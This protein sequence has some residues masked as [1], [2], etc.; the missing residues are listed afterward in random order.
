MKRLWQTLC[1]QL[2]STLR[3]RVHLALTT[4][5]LRHQLA[6][7]QRSATRP[8]CWPAD[9]CLWVLFSLVWA[10]W[11]EALEIAQADTVRRWRRQGF[12]QLVRWERGRKRPG[13]PAIAAEMRAL[14]RRMSRANLLW[15][16]PRLHGE[17][18][19][20]GIKVSRTTV[21]NYMVCRSGLP[22]PSWR[23][24]IR[25][26][27][28][29]LIAS[30]A[31]TACFSSVCTLAVTVLYTLRRWLERVVASGLSG[32]SRRSWRATLTSLQPSDTAC[33]PAVWSL[34]GGACVSVGERGP[35]DARLARHGDA[36]S[37]GLS[38]HWGIISVCRGSSPARR[39]G[40]Y[41]LMQRQGD[42]QTT[43]QAKDASQ[44]VA[45]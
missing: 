42:C 45:A 12:R 19:M 7:L 37:A 21:A 34:G 14:I 4:M 6:V 11:S 22:S 43:G 33:A 36:V 38:I 26:H 8:P 28:H 16:A 2:T 39:W 29:E 13:R 27:A 44:R 40:V 17:L 24:F 3:E 20:L 35:P 18:A 32:A 5:A 31:Y 23:T 10:R 41:A 25:H 1:Q 30:G 15:G 9:R